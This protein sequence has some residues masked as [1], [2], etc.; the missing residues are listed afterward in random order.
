MTA[1]DYL[2]ERE[3]YAGARRDGRITVWPKHNITPQI[4]AWIQQ[5]KNQ[6][7]LEL[8]PRGDLNVWR[9]KID[10]KPITMLSLCSTQ[11]EALQSA[12]GR[13]PVAYIEILTDG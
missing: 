11:D 3:L 10:G 4:R 13:W 6:L 7:L 9:I 2:R 1:I 8:K 5:H 12:R